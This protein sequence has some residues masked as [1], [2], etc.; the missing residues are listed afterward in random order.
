[1]G[2]YTHYCR[3]NSHRI[4]LEQNESETSPKLFPNV[5]R[6]DQAQ[7]IPSNMFENLLKQLAI[8]LGVIDAWHPY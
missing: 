4:H 2:A 6:N 1:M 3:L 8:E 7:E 5:A